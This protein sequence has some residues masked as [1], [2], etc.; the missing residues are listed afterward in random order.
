MKA[1]ERARADVA[2]GRVWKAR[3]RLTGALASDRSSQEVLQALG[4][5]Y[6]LMG[7]LPAAG[8]HWFL[9]DAEE[10]RAAVA[11]VAMRERYRTPAALY[12]ALPLKAAPDAYPEQVRARLRTLLADDDVRRMHER[13]R[14]GREPPPGAGWLPATF[15][16]ALVVP[17]LLGLAAL[18]Y[19]LWRLVT[20]LV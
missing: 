19:L 15:I 8:L 16:G 6:F 7:D 13:S 10:P 12:A 17:W 3:D 18:G 11:E 4:D 1:V 20:W 9:T 2:A 14:P 5:V